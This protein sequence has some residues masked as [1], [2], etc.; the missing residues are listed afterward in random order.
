MHPEDNPDIPPDHIMEKAEDE[1]IHDPDFVIEFVHEDKDTLFRFQRAVQD[2]AMKLW[3]E[4]QR[5]VADRLADEAGE[6][7]DA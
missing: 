1:L 2:R 7:A 4:E 5:T 6:N 3:D